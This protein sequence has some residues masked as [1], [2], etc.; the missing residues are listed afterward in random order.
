MTVALS[1][2]NPQVGNAVTAIPV[3]SGGVSPYTLA[4]QWKSDGSAIGG[5]VAPSYTPV[6]SDIGKKLVCTVTVTD[7]ESDTATGDS[8]ETNAVA[9][10]SGPPVIGSASLSGGPGFS[11][12]TYTTTLIGYDPGVPAAT[13]GM[14]AKV[15]GALSIAGE[16]SPITE[17]TPGETLSGL[18]ASVGEGSITGDIFAETIDKN[19][20]RQNRKSQGFTFTGLN[21]QDGDEIK[22]YGQSG[23]GRP[24]FLE[25]AGVE[26]E[27]TLPDGNNNDVNSYGFSNE[28]TVT[29]S[30][31][32]TNFYCNMGSSITDPGGDASCGA[33][34]VNGVQIFNGQNTGVLLD[35]TNDKDL[36]NG[37]FVEGDPVQG[38]EDA[39]NL[40]IIKYKVYDSNIENAFDGSG[41]AYIRPAGTGTDRYTVTLI[42]QPYVEAGQDIVI[43]GIRAKNTNSIN[44]K[45]GSET[46]TKTFSAV[47]ENW[48][49]ACTAGTEVTFT[50]GTS[51]YLESFWA[52][53]GNPGD[54]D[55]ICYIKINGV[56]ML[57]N[58]NMQCRIQHT[59]KAI[60]PDAPS[61]VVSGGTWVVGET[62]KNS[63]VNPVSVKP[64]T[65][66]IVGV[67][68][69][70]LSFSGDKDLEQV[71]ASDD[72]YQDA[73]YTANTSEIVGV[74]DADPSA[75]VLSFQDTTDLDVFKPGDMVLAPTYWNQDENWSNKTTL[76][77]SWNNEQGGP[78]NGK[79]GQVSD[80]ICGTDNA[81][82]KGTVV[83]DLGKDYTGTARINGNGTTG[84]TTTMTLSSGQ[85]TSFTGTSGDATG[86]WSAET[87][88][89]TF[90]TITISVS[91]D[92]SGSM[93]WT[94]I[95]INGQLLVDSGTPIVGGVQVVSVKDP[96]L[97]AP[98]QMTV[99]GGDWTLWNQ[100]ETWSNAGVT[101]TGSTLQQPFENL[102]DGNLSTF[103]NWTASN[104][105]DPVVMD[106]SAFNLSGKVEVYQG[107]G[108]NSATQNGQLAAT[109]SNPLQ[110]L[111]Y[112][113]W[114]TLQ[115]SG[116]FTSLSLAS[117]GANSLARA[118]T[119]IKIDGKM[120][121]D[122]S[123]G[124]GPTVSCTYQPGT[125][126]VA[127]PADVAAKTV[128][129]GTIGNDYPLRWV[130]NRNRR[131]TMDRKPAVATSAFLE[132][133]GTQVTG[134]TT[135]DPGYKPIDPSLQLT[136]TDPAPSGES[137]DTELPTGTTMKT[138][139]LATNSE[140]TADSGWS[141]SVVGYGLDLSST[142]D[143]FRHQYLEIAS[144]L[145][146]FNN[147]ACVYQ[148]Q[149][150]QEK[151][152]EVNEKIAANLGITVAELEE[153]VGEEE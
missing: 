14:K 134:L 126:I 102:F 97:G 67:D 136:F 141:N 64:V 19:F 35:L 101:A 109:N 49:T 8:P 108:G 123:I 5:A 57:N 71:E 104:T 115:E 63:I 133:S 59:V 27:I 52:S 36:R 146:T 37:A 32:F 82:S 2:L 90:N 47:D 117:S 143:E 86:K 135:S 72:V 15:T 100:S 33:I 11:G 50:V 112:Q 110:A 87:P 120:L 53:G 153:L 46:I 139:V 34:Y 31:A 51:G 147:R 149:C 9:A 54:A 103:T 95:E 137:W 138:R 16:T 23:G 129:L 121:V 70:T 39:T 96:D 17:V 69:T 88:G 106:F 113:S 119:A 48:N 29:A 10:V 132:W 20:C 124:P 41:A 6:A 62:V 148:G 85:T 131:M 78:F 55:G 89:S 21:V 22:I 127:A 75:I 4:Y 151:R 84:Y 13:L 92:G 144:H 93:W 42:T 68:G 94:G 56:T 111:T 38:Y 43:K 60:N 40:G 18:S 91:P 118:L 66:E 3:V 77:S 98:Y 25:I 7:D 1:T 142:E 26:Y 105:S 58:A 79:V 61:M 145:A 73:G 28:I 114:T 107:G 44:V 125:G 99:D 140:G 65:D 45:V 76:G 128:T 83:I 150:A 24:V 81:T 130:A 12:Q 74:N 80:G 30:G 116:S 152:D 122:P